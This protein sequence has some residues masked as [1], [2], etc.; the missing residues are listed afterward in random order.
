MNFTT[1]NKVLVIAVGGG[2]DSVSTLMLQLQLNKKFGYRPNHIDIVAVLPDVLD[3]SG[4]IET[5]HPLISIITPETQ[6]SVQGKAITAFPEKVL[7]QNLSYFKELPIQNLFGISLLKG[8]VG[9]ADALKHL[10]MSKY[11]LILGIDVGGDFIAHKNNAGVLSPLMDGNIM[12]ALRELEDFIVDANL[13]TKLIFSIFGLGA[14]GES[15]TEMLHA[16]LELLPDKE[17]HSFEA[18]D[19][20]DFE[21]FYRTIVEPNR[22]SRST[23][24]TLREIFG[25]LHDN[26]ST[27]RGRFHIKTTENSRADIYY[28][29]FSHYVDPEFFG[30]FYLFTDIS[31]V[32]N[33]FCP[34]TYNCVEWFLK[35][36]NGDTKY[37]HELNGQAYLDLGRTLEEP[38]L[39]GVSLFMGTPSNKF[40]KKIQKEITHKVGEAIMNDVYDIGLI[41]LE[42]Q[43]E[44]PPD[45]KVYKMQIIGTNLSTIA[46]ITKNAGYANIF[47]HWIKSNVGIKGKRKPR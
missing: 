21:T 44:L 35:V 27:F 45:L 11:D 43:Q 16:A 38:A 34:K 9:V 29:E 30:K 40:D 1:F 46:M 42:Y 12:F 3:Y 20:K 32:T 36:Q 33:S 19:V 17:E 24:Y 18:A 41:Y 7:A 13:D 5:Q 47:Y 39:K 10:A 4:M 8:S 25:P 28:G 31:K 15:S 26:P 6:R 2:N 37:N 22:Y 23:D 14:D